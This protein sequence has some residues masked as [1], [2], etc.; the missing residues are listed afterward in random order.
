MQQL[1][2]RLDEFQS[3]QSGDSFPERIGHLDIELIEVDPEMIISGPTIPLPNSNIKTNP[4]VIVVEGTQTLTDQTGQLIV[5]MRDLFPIVASDVIKEKFNCSDKQSKAVLNKILDR[6]MKETGWD[7]RISLLHI[8]V[9]EHLT[10]SILE[11]RINQLSGLEDTF[12]IYLSEDEAN[13]KFAG[14]PY[15]SPSMKLGDIVVRNFDDGNEYGFGDP[16]NEYDFDDDDDTE[17]DVG[18]P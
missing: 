8:L 13:I 4:D 6:T 5:E 12:R 17:Y 10:P 7:K 2:S 18:S 14:I 16:G 3:F 15:H 9:R 1:E 11:D